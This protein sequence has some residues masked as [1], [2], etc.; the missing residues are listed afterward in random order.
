MPAAKYGYFRI[1]AALFTV[2][3]ISKL[4]SHIIEHFVALSS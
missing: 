2:K 3:K 1:V 4:Y